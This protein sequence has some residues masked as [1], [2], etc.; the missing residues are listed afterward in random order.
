MEILEADETQLEQLRLEVQRSD[1]APQQREMESA[2][3]SVDDCQE[4]YARALVPCGCNA[5]AHAT[6]LLMKP[7]NDCSLPGCQL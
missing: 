4:R 5:D 2:K 7:C 1:G 6:A 3:A